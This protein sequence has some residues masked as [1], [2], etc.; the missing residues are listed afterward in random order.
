MANRSGPFHD[1]VT[2]VNLLD[3]LKLEHDDL[4]TDPTSTRHAINAAFTA[5]HMTEWIWG[6]R[7]KGN[8]DYRSELGLVKKTDGK[9]PRNLFRDNM[10]ANCMSL[11][12]MEAITNGAK[13]L[14]RDAATKVNSGYSN[15]YRD[16]YEAELFVTLE[17][18]SVVKFP[19]ELEK[20]I[21][22]WENFLDQYPAA[23]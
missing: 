8:G 21:R 23:E 15:T 20:A 3:K 18:G 19:D 16:S 17:N 2:P 4:S 14:S 7:L 12:T 9:K 6:L 22:H 10:K 5:W 13:H 11:V 1:L